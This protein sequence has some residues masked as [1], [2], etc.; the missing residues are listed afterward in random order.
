M[1]DLLRN[2]SRFANAQ[3]EHCNAPQYGCQLI[4]TIVRGFSAMTM[5]EGLA[6]KQ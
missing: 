4:I 1:R 3:D 6:E 5:N 2:N